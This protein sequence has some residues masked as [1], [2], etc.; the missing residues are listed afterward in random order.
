MTNNHPPTLGITAA[1]AAAAG[2]IAAGVGSLASAG[3]SAYGAANAPEGVAAHDIPVSGYRPGADPLLSALSMQGMLGMGAFDPNV[4]SQAS[5]VQQLLSQIQ[6]AGQLSQRD[7]REFQSALGIKPEDYEA[8]ST[9]GR[10]EAKAYLKSKGYTG[11]VARDMMRGVDRADQIVGGHGYGTLGELLKANQT[12][13]AKIPE[14]QAQYQPVADRMR[15]AQIASTD[16][17]A[18]Y[19]QNLPNLLTGDA[20][21][22][23]DELRREALHSAQKYGH[24]PYMGLEQAR[25]Q[26][27]QRA[28]QLIQGEQAVMSGQQQLAL[29]AAQLRQQGGATAANV[30]AGQAAMLGNALQSQQAAQANQAAMWSNAG[31][32][33]GQSGLILGDMMGGLGGGPAAGPGSPNAYTIGAPIATVE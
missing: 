9:L 8:I 6:G 25:S 17:T 14:L 30:G 16:R 12:Y 29:P 11:K 4:Y 15:A 31:N 10:K 13:L 20:N 18:G 26:A 2:S 21:P 33:I 27:L 19:L 1:G 28:L 32:A 5:P 23:V 7:F 22:F 3:L 24:N